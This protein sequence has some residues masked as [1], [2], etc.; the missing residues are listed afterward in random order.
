MHVW[1][2]AIGEGREGPTPHGTVLHFLHFLL[3]YPSL[4]FKHFLGTLYL[5]IIWN[6]LAFCK[7]D[8]KLSKKKSLCGNSW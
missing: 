3:L 6:R 1:K 5:V 8:N 7:C 2:S 4:R